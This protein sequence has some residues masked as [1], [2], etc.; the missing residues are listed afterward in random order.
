VLF[1]A[2]LAA[3][4]VGAEAAEV[5]EAGQHAHHGVVG[6]LDG[7]VVALGRRQAGQ[8]APAA[9]QLEAGRPQEQGVQPVKGRLTVAAVAGQS[10]HPG[11][12]LGVHR[13]V[14]VREGSSQHAHRDLHALLGVARG[15]GLTRRVVAVWL[16]AIIVNL[17]VAGDY[18]DIALRDFGLSLGALA[19]AGSVTVVADRHLR[20]DDERMRR[21]SSLLEGA[22]DRPRTAR[23]APRARARHLR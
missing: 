9:A 17:L 20:V 4:E 14:H 22:R 23:R 6:G 8:L 11:A 7:Q 15:A 18:F 12:R 3:G 21:P 1:A 16:W 10:G 13:R 19:P 2:G 5:A